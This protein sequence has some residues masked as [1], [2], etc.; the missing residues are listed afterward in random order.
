MLEYMR[1]SD[2]LSAYKYV[3]LGLGEVKG[4]VNSLV[5]ESIRNCIKVVLDVNKT[6]NEQSNVFED[7]K[8]L[9][10]KG[11]TLKT[12]CITLTKLDTEN[13]TR[14]LFIL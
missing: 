6:A 9:W 12:V 5:K 14:G 7:I 13:L 4:S 1:F 3:K 10:L 2:Y 11:L 8:L